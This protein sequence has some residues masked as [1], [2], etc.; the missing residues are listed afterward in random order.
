[1]KK[2]LILEA[3]GTFTLV[4]VV[5]LSLLG[6][7]PF[8]ITPL[9]AALTLTLFVYTIGSTSGCHIN[10]AITLGLWSVQKIK[11]HE[12][13]QYIIA[14]FLGAGIAAVFLSAVQDSALAFEIIPNSW[15]VFL[16][17][18]IGALFFA[19]GVAAVAHGKAASDMSGAVV[20]GS[21]LLGIAIAAGL[22]SSGILNPAVALS[23]GQLNVG[24][25]LGSMVGAVLGMNLYKR[26]VS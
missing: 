19:F 7:I 10:P 17:E 3:L 2:K 15:L 8:I 11:S 12:A 23:L 5:Q 1:M 22:G 13:V 26:L 6:N 9:L 21:L 18:A 14:Q 25:I 16:A 4:L 20:G 24:Y